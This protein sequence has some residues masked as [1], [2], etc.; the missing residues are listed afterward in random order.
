MVFDATFDGVLPIELAG[1]Q[2]GYA[3]GLQARDETFDLTPDALNDLTVSPCPFNNP[4]SVALGNT[5]TL[6]CTQSTLTSPT[7]RSRSWRARCSEHRS[8]D[9][10]FWN[11]AFRSASD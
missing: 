5:D 7:G 10:T 4:V 11:W 9:L 8:D 1:G 6:D 3:I 2:V